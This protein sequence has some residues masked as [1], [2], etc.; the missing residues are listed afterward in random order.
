[1]AVRF[2]GPYLNQTTESDPIMI[3]VPMDKSGIGANEAGLPK[4]SVNSDSMQL[5]HVGGALGK[6]E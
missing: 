6:G 5:K 3:R 1:M 4:G 2:P